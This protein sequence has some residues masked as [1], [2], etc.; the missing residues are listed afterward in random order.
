MKMIN[1]KYHWVVFVLFIL[2]F[3]FNAYLDGQYLSDMG[4]KFSKNPRQVWIE[5]HALSLGISFL[6]LGVLAFLNRT[7]IL[8]WYNKSKLK[9]FVK[10]L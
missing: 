7:R 6:F 8:K 2:L 10:E 3:L 1:P 5:A 4:Y 9:S